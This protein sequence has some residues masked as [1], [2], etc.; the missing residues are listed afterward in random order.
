[1]KVA[2]VV[3]KGRLP[4]EHIDRLRPGDPVNS[5]NNVLAERPSVTDGQIKSQRL[6]L[7]EVN[8]RVTPSRDSI[9]QPTPKTKG[10]IEVTDAIAN[11]E[12]ATLRMRTTNEGKPFISHFSEVVNDERNGGPAPFPAKRE[13]VPAFPFL[14]DH[15]VLKGGRMAKIFITGATGGFG[16]LT[17]K[18]L[19]KEGHT[20][21][22]SVRDIAGRNKTKVADLEKLGAKFVEM[23]ITNDAS[24][25][26]GIETGIQLLNGIDVLINNA[27]VGVLGLTEAFTTDDMKRVFEVN[28]FGLQRVS[29]AVI[30]Y[31]RKTSRGLVINISSLLGR[32]TVP[33][34][35]PYNASK[36]AVE[37][38][39]ENYRTELSQS[40]IEVCL[41]EP[42]GYPT[43]FIDNLV[44]PSD[45][46][47]AKAYGPMGNMPEAFLENFE[48]ALAANPAQ[49]PS[50]VAQAICKLV[51]TPHASRPFRTI[52][53]AMGM[54]GP[55]GDYNAILAK[56]TEGIYSNFGIANL[57]A[58]KT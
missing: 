35:G 32:I 27:G 31:M 38:L 2:S 12:V 42:G 1:M 55:I 8:G 26:R 36:W 48:K 41:V 28:V 9:Q 22:G 46:E 25:N 58:V 53:D 43:A 3:E 20:V 54:G 37:G 6:N 34:Y 15:C 40:G 30:P 50:H 51:K 39:T 11:V 19:I 5:E 7:H 44:R 13:K 29:R 23:D 24:V 47:R 14:C 56:I 33:F 18:E 10:K 4:I 52:V 16:M 17:V 49:D 45:S 57:L 21:V